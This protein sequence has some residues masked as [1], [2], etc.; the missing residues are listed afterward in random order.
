MSSEGKFTF[1][2][3]KTHQ[4]SINP[5]HSDAT[6]TFSKALLLGLDKADAT[7]CYCLPRS[8]VSRQVDLPLVKEHFPRPAD[9][10]TSGRVE[11]SCLTLEH[12]D[13]GFPNSC[14]QWHLVQHLITAGQQ[15]SESS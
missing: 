4:V 14:L 9:E 13:G 11:K 7:V 15:S 1:N 10:I 2:C 5:K 6:Y 3:R 8:S 12:F